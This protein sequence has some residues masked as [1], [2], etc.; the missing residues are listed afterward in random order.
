M[1]LKLVKFL[2]G[3]VILSSVFSFVILVMTAIHHFKIKNLVEE[4]K[5]EAAR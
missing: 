1:S 3:G 5:A 2:L 4:T